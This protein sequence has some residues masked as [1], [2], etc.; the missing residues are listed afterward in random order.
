[1]K[2]KIDLGIYNKSY[3][4]IENGLIPSLLSFYKKPRQA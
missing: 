1:M 4:E 2:N 3:E